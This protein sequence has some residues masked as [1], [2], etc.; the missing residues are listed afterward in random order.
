MID[1]LS[2]SNF[3]CFEAQDV[4]LKALTVLTGLNGSG[5]STVIQSLLLLR[6]SWLQGHLPNALALNGDLIRIGTAVDALYEHG[7]DKIALGIKESQ[8]GNRIYA[9]SYDPSSE[10]LPRVDFLAG[11][12]SDA[13]SV[14]F[15]ER[16]QYLEAERLGPRAYFAAADFAVRKQR[17]LGKQGEFAAHFLHVFRDEACKRAEVF[18]PDA[19]SS[20]LIDQVEAWLSE[21]SPGTRITTSMQSD[22]DLVG[23]GYAFE[24]KAGVTNR[25]RTTNVGFG[26]TYV[27]P[28]IIACLVMEPAGLLIVE[29]PEVHLHPTAQSVI[30]RLLTLTAASG[31]QVVVETHSD[32]IVNSVR[33]SVKHKLIR[34]QDVGV[35]FF[36]RRDR[37][38]NPTMTE[39]LI[40]DQGNIGVWPDGFLDEWEKS[41]L[42]LIE[43]K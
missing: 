11:A 6:Q 2:I 21:I 12:D 40:D 38:P 43:T 37:E 34:R 39:L 28:I 10:V 23:L 42:A 17:Q 25:Y 24:T 4:P 20:R 3:K 8:V 14:L 22:M 9:F 1:E 19:Q 26:L 30:S 5:K 16:F 15:G 32:H 35:L 27:L 29:N 31:V 13:R 41:L 33:L 36:A 7:G 18:H